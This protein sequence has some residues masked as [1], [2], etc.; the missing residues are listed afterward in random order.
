MR[1]SQYVDRYI[2][3]KFIRKYFSKKRNRAGEG[4]KTVSE[5]TKSKRKGPGIV[6]ANYGKKKV[7]EITTTTTTT[8]LT[9]PHPLTNLEIQ[10]VLSYSR[11]AKLEEWNKI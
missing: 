5:E 7:R 11:A 2:G 1:I 3:C 4:G 8:K 10:K 6:R 9:P